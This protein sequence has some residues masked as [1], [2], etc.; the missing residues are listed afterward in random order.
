MG[1]LE[2]I[3]RFRP[4]LSIETGDETDD[5]S[6]IQPVRSLGY[7]V[8]SIASK[9]FSWPNFK[10]YDISRLSKDISVNAICIPDGRNQMDLLGG[11]PRRELRTLAE[12]REEC[13]RFVKR[14]RY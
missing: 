3:E 2:T 5:L 4:F 8:F 7:R 1:A 14:P 13:R 10:R 11:I 6:W 12:L 9:A